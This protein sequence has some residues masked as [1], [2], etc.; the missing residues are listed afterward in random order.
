MKKKA[1]IIVPTYNEKENIRALL[2]V[3]VEIFSHITDWSLS[4]LVVDDNSP[5]GTGLVVKEFES[6]GLPVTLY[7]NMQKEGLGHAYLVGMK[8]AIHTLAADVIF[9][10]DADFSHDP[11]KIP[12]FLDAIDAG[13]DLVVGSRYVTGGSIPADWGVHRK[14]LSRVGNLVNMIVLWNFSVRDWTTGYRAITRECFLALEAEMSADRFSGYTFQIGFLHKAIRKK[15]RIKEVPIHFVDRTVGS[16]K[17]GPDY[18]KNALLYILS[19]RVKEVAASRVFK[20]A[21]VGGSGAL[22]QLASLQLFRKAFSYELAFILAIE[23]AIISNFIWSNTWTFA[24]R[25]LKLIEIPKKF[26]QFNLASFGSILIQTTIAFLGKRFIGL[27]PLFVIPVV[28]LSVDT[29]LVFA[30]V[31]IL[32]GMG[33]NYF[34]YSRIVWKTA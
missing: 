31:G 29:G 20:F 23:L 28:H 13:A 17:L 16:S 22:V 34:A 11:K 30:M 32:I 7:S 1:I 9:E 10:F 6:Q 18:I 15:F 3:L 12:E 19:A 8:H 4:V 26:L 14:F 2:P 33:W 27:L 5:D 25:H 21:I 24:D